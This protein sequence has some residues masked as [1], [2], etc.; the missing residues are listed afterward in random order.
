[1][2]CRNTNRANAAKLKLL[3]WFDEELEKMPRTEENAEYL[4]SFRE[5]CD[6]QI[7]ELDLAN[8]SSVLKFA[9]TMDRMYVA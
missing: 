5:G 7:A 4:R 9:A 1:M 2:A 3:Q 8:F 6:V